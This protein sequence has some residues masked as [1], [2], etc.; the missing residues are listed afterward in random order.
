MK[1]EI[2]YEFK[3]LYRGDFRITDYNFGEGT[4][5]FARDEPMVYS[6]MALFKYVTK[7]SH[8]DTV[9]EVLVTY[10]CCLEGFSS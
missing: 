7:T 10:F 1:K 6:S 2:L 5:L 4:I 9:W 8:T 3:A